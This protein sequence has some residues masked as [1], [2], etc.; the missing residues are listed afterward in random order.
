METTYSKILSK[1]SDYKICCRCGCAN[2]YE[3]KVCH[4]CLNREFKEMDFKWI[5]EEYEFYKSEGYSEN[6]IDNLKIN[7]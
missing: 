2:W 4:N 6:E 5:D 1:M 3:N 7:V